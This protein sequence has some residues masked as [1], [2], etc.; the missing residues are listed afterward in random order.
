MN[1]DKHRGVSGKNNFGTAIYYL[2]QAVEIATQDPERQCELM[3]DYNV[4][5]ELKDELSSIDFI[6]TEY[7]ESFSDSQIVEMKKLSD[8]AASIPDSVCEES[9]T[10]TANLESMS[11][12]HWV[13]VRSQATLLQ[14]ILAELGS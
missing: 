10:R 2:A 6:I 12:P 14:P 7:E 4:A 5:W 1:K 11:D 13:P 3:G 8:L 9:K